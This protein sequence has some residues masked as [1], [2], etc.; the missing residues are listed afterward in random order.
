MA[1]QRTRDLKKEAS[2]RR[3]IRKQARSGLTIRAWCLDQRVNEATFHWWRR[4]LAR[5]DAEQ[6]PPARRPA[7]RSARGTRSQ[8][9][10]LRRAQLQTASARGGRRQVRQGRRTI[11]KTPSQPQQVRPVASS[12]ERQ[13]QALA[14]SAEQHSRDSGS[15]PVFVPVCLAE[16]GRETDGSRIEIVLTDGRCVRVTGSVDRRTLADVL[17]VLTSAPSSEASIHTG[18][19]SQREPRTC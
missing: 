5:R 4:E 13:N 2:W 15:R 16:E 3:L 7:P 1:K 14:S 8:T 19:Q 11:R 10:S 6:S 12:V 9:D 18:S 17:A